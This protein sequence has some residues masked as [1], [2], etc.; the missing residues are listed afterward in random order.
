MVSSSVRQDK[1]RRMARLD[2][3]QKCVM[4]LQAMC[5]SS[6][7]GESQREPAQG[8]SSHTRLGKCDGCACCEG[9]EKCKGWQEEGSTN[10][11]SNMQEEKSKVVVMFRYTK[12]RA[13]VHVP[14][15]GFFPVAFSS[16]AGF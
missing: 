12:I 3:T 15:L 16:P 10:G 11:D 14:L 1:R 9:E 8:G 13:L 2:K 4:V 6:A 7:S 5:N